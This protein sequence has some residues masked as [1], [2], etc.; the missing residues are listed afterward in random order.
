MADTPPL[1]DRIIVKA[2]LK[3][4]STLQKDAAREIGISEATLSEWIN[5]KRDCN[6]ETQKKLALWWKRV[7]STAVENLKIAQLAIADS[8]PSPNLNLNLKDRP[9]FV[10]ILTEVGNGKRVKIGRTSDITTRLRNLGT[11]N[12]DLRLESAMHFTDY[13]QAETD[14][15]KRFEKSRDKTNR[16][17]FSVAPKDAAAALYDLYM[18]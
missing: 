12:P 9:G 6:E 16:E 4:S 11:G 13:V 17:W 1:P 2:H 5:G 15:H 7:D 18:K 3:N 10:Y 14:L 8:D